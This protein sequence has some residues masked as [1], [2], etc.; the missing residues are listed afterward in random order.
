MLIFLDLETTG[1]EYED[2][3]C[4]IGIIGVRD[5]GEITIFYELINEGKKI[6]PKASSINHITNE[7]IKNKPTFKDTQSFKF[8]MEQNQASSTIVVHNA[9]FDME[10]LSL[11]GFEFVGNVIDTLRSVKHLIP[12]CELFSLQVLRYELKLYKKEDDELQKCGIKDALV[13]HNALS[14]ALVVKLLFEYLLEISSFEEMKELSQKK[15]LLDKF[16]F[17]K[18]QGRYIEDIAMNDSSYLIWMLNLEDLDEDMRYS[19]EYY[20]QG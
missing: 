5:S 13:A 11:S 1:L 8:L 3:I 10:K 18:Y 7:M 12:E 14:D 4:S 2:K 20:L 9:K 6:P 15:V 19:I 16:G 17:G